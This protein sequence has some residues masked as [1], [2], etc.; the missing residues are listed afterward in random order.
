MA[1][2]KVGKII[3]RRTLSDL[4]ELFRIT[5]EDGSSFPDYKAGQYIALSRDNCRLTKKVVGSNAELKFVYDLDESGKAKSGTVTHSYSISSP[6][7]ETKQKCYLEFYVVLEMIETG[8]PGRL[9]ESLFH[10]DP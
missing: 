1:E 8:M 4:L 10:I 5:P 6:P 7:V 9:S 2:K 3:Y